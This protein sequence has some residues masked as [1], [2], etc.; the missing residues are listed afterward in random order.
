MGGILTELNIVKDKLCVINGIGINCLQ[1]LGDLNPEIRDFAC[2][3]AMATD[4]PIVREAVSAALI[5]SLY[6][7]D[8]RLLTGKAEIMA[9]YRRDC[10][11]VDQDVR[12]LRA[13]TVRYG[14]AEDIDENGALLVRFADGH[15]ETVNSGEISVRG[16]YG[17]A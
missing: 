3:L 12:L 11:T 14:H 6:E 1:Q 4:H 15:T 5:A 17:Y 13:D 2:S 10:I 8:Q 16:M 7:M 9:T